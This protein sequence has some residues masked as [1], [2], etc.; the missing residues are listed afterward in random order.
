MTGRRNVIGGEDMKLHAYDCLLRLKHGDMYVIA[1]LRLSCG[2][3]KE[4]IWTT[5][6]I[7]MLNTCFI[8]YGILVSVLLVDSCNNRWR[9]MRLTEILIRIFVLCF[10][11]HWRY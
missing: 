2:W 9:I 5:T 6:K 7:H 8:K 4:N 10:F 1:A 3:P 11:F